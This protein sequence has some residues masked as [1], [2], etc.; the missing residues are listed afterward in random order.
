MADA[1]ASSHPL[2]KTVEDFLVWVEPQPER[3]EFVAGRLVLM[4]GGSEQHNDIRVNL[5]TALRGRL[6]GAP[7]TPNGSD[8]L[9]RID[10]RTGRFPDAS[11]SCGRAGGNAITDPVAL[12]EILSPGTELMDRTDK[13]RDYQRLPSLR[14]Y[15]LIAQD[16]ARVEIYTRSG[17][18]WRFEEI[19]D[20]AGAVALVALGIDLPLAEIYEGVP[21]ES[22][23]GTSPVP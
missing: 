2:L 4:A 9:I 3:Y 8:L 10:D 15:V 12:F 13:R 23:P 20:P 21:L 22:G 14:H 11:V 5:L 17:V 18:D 6:R 19:M 16:A 1:T 7:C